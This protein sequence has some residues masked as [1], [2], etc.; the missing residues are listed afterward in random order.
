M[1]FLRL[2]F[3]R[4]ASCFDSSLDSAPPVLSLVYILIAL[5]NL[6][7]SLYVAFCIFALLC[8]CYAMECR[9]ATVSRIA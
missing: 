2:C 3:H 6:L 8:I 9:I 5:S 7:P 1:S 4:R